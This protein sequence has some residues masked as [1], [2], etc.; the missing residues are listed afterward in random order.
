LFRCWLLY[1]DLSKSRPS[2]SRAACDYDAEGLSVAL[3]LGNEV[4]LALGGELVQTVVM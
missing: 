4:L 2:E 1:F 3:D